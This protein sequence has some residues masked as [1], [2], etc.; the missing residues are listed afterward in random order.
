MVFSKTRMSRQ[1][2][3][4]NLMKQTQ[5]KLLNY[6]LNFNSRLPLKILSESIFTKNCLIQFEWQLKAIWNKSSTSVTF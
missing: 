2:D 3:L 1:F 4:E 5:L 6:F